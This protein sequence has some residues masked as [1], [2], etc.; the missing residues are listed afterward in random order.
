[1]KHLPIRLSNNSRILCAI[2][3]YWA[4]AHDLSLNHINC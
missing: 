4:A 2:F 3:E 1:M